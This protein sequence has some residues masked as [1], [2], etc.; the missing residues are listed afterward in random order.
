M[1]E[2]YKHL[3]SP[4]KIGNVVLKNRMISTK[5]VPPG[6]NS[7][8][9]YPNAALI[10]HMAKLAKSG[11]AI[12]T[13]H[14]GHWE[15]PPTMKAEVGDTMMG[16][17]V[18]AG[19]KGRPCI[20][21]PNG[22]PEYV[23]GQLE[24]QPYEVE[25]PPV[26]VAFAQ[27][28]DAIHYYGSLASVSMMDIEPN[29]YCIV[30]VDNNDAL[31]EGYRLGRGKGMTTEQLEEMIDDF[32]EKAVLYKKLGFDMVCIY[33]SYR[34]S[35]LAQS[36]SPA[37]NT[38]T[39]KYGGSF[40]NRARLT[41]ELFQKIKAACGPDFLIEAQITG[42]EKE[43]GYTLEDFIRYAKLVEP[44]VDIFQ[45][46]GYD[47]DAAH[48]TGFTMEKGE[49]PMTLR[50]ARALKES[51]VNIIAAPNGGYHDPDFID[52][53][54]ADGKMDMVA[55][56]RSFIA[57]PDYEQ[58]LREDRREDIVPCLMCNK[59]HGD[60]MPL[61]ARCS[62]NPVVGLSSKLCYMVEE[63]ACKKKVAVIGGGPAGMKAA[64]TAAQRGHAVTLYEAEKKLGGQLFHADYS[65]YKWPLKDFKDYMI[66]QL[67]KEKVQV[68]LDTP[69]TIE[70]IS[71]GKYDAIIYAAGAV[72]TMPKL[73]GIDHPSVRHVLEAYGHQAEFGKRVVIIGG[74]ETPLE[75]AFY[76]KDFG[77]EIT[78]MTRGHV[79]APE[80]QGVHGSKFAMEKGLLQAGAKLLFRSTATKISDQGVHYTDAQGAEHV[81]PCDTVLVTGGMQPKLDN[82][83]QFAMLAREFYMAGDCVK[84][85]DMVAVNRSAFAA[86]SRL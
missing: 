52:K 69:A 13:C 22:Q 7:A 64:V 81:I 3:L 14:G 65:K 61:R 46:R 20:I 17:T 19:K 74:A 4:I 38:R 1:P 76:L 49:E 5:A 66:R 70:S 55:M 60:N 41:L 29:G 59:C 54:I 23:D 33:M 34:G 12:V 2:K 9:N 79:L 39:D 6:L 84:V 24:F 32:V 26:Q 80:A 36:L 67:E 40:E 58:K 16:Q 25:K 37:V 44:Y 56:A 53:A 62:V 47:G 8:E 18:F 78:L 86:A 75:T 85:G 45:I 73:E 27:L 28:A 71:E 57:D 50:A 77:Y 43:G 11:A 82:V 63:P 51:G 68:L 30:D 15:M 21:G 31:A 35:I 72:P 42:E 83:E 48:P 10:D